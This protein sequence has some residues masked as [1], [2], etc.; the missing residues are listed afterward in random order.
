MADFAAAR[1]MMVDGQVRTNDVTDPRLLDAMLDVPRDK[2]LP[3]TK[4]GLAY[5]DMDIPL[6][7]AGKGSVRRLLKPMTLA[8]MI[9]ATRPGETDRVLDVGCATGYA[10]ALLARLAAEVVAIEEDPALLPQAREA[11]VELGVGQAEVVS[12]PLAKG[13]SAR[14]PYDVVLVEGAV[15]VVPHA[16][17]DQLAEGGRLVC[18][19]GTG[20]AGKAMLY[21]RDRGEISGRA[22]FDCSAA[23]LPGFE[24]PAAFVF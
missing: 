22:V 23:A 15:E 17:L 7:D 13:W 8:K 24:K 21:R 10:A 4:R 9:H 1:R 14:A 16:L 6:T 2:F 18:V 20:P 12:G 19:M 5:L 11:L 3:R